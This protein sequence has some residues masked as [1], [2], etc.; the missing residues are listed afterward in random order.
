M[1][2][3]QRSYTAFDRLDVFVDAFCARK[4]DDRLDDGECVTSSVIDLAREQTW[5][6][7]SFLAVGDIDRDAT[8]PHH[9]ACSIDTCRSRTCAPTQFAGRTLDAKLDLLS[10]LAHRYALNVRA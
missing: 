6:S 1:R 4:P 2:S 7:L 3:R 5:A 9:A 8:D 10:A